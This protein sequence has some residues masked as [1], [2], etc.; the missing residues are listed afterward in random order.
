MEVEFTRHTIEKMNARHVSESDIH[1]VLKDPDNMFYDKDRGTFVVAK[2]IR[3][4][5]LLVLYT[6]K[7]KTF[8][9]VTVYFS[10]KID[11]LI[12]SKIR[13]GTWIKIE[14]E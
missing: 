5:Y 4:R 2:S 9:V 10:T 7:N 8:R 14:K 6:R 3:D 13:R 12:D 11:K 1:L